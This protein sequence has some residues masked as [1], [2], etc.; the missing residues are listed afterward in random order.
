M[1]CGSLSFACMGVLANDLGSSCDWRVI[2]LARSGLALLFAALLARAAGARLVFRRPGIL[3]VRSL[4]G[5]VSLVCTFYA[6]TR[7][8]PHVV[9][10]LTNTFPLWVA[11]LSWPLL[12]ERPAGSVWLAAGCGVLGVLLIQRPFHHES[13]GAGDVAALLALVSSFATAVAMLGLHH[14]QE[15]DTRAIVVHFSSVAVLFCLGAIAVGGPVAHLGG[16]L[17]ARTLVALLGVGLTATVGQ[18]FLTRA[19]AAGPPARV[20][21]IGLT[22]IVFALA[23]DVG[24]LHQPFHPSTLLGVALVLAPTAWVMALRA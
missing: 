1:L 15:V 4:A 23:L 18:L 13:V 5:S 2:A 16:V 17:Q 3:W 21:V 24:L 14:L 7:L 20:S 8:P 6:L 12:G 22:Q 11:V 9:L 19:F 10:T